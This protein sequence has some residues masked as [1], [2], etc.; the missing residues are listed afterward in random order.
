MVAVSTGAS[1]RD[2]VVEG[3]AA[4]LIAVV[5]VTAGVVESGVSALI[6]V[7]FGAASGLDAASVASGEAAAAVSMAGA[8]VGSNGTM[9]GTVVEFAVVSGAAVAGGGASSPQA[10]SN[11]ATMHNKI[12]ARQSFRLPTCLFIFPQLY[13]ILCPSHIDGAEFYR[14]IA[15]P[16]AHR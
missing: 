3:K 7:P 11:S 16:G 9:V 4:A 5:T 1:A 8:T 2:S 15:W 6:G 10:Q 12:T 13:L 14:I